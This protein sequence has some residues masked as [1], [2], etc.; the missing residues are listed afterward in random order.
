MKL[1]LQIILI[2]IV[3]FKTETLLSENNLFNVNNIKLD[4]N[5]KISNDT[6]ADKAIKKGF[7]ELI[8]K[9]LLKEDINKLSNLNFSSIKELV[10][11][12]QVSQIPDEKDNGELAS[13]SVTFDKDKIHELFYNQG[14]LYSEI[15]DKEIF[16][17]PVLIKE[18]EIYIFNNN[19]FYKYWNE[20]YTV[21]LIEFILPIENIE[22]IQKINKNKKNLIDIE[23][24]NLFKEYSKKNL[25]LVLIEEN[26]SKNNR[27]Y[28]KTKIQGKKISKSLNIK[29]ENEDVKSQYEQ[30]IKISKNELTNLVKSENLIDIRTPSFLNV[31]LDLNKTTN[32]VEFNLRV[33]NI[34]LVENVYVQEFNKDYLK[35]RIKYLGKLER[36]ID[37]FKKAKINL[38]FIN[39]QWFLKFI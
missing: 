14:I 22:I 28:L 29:K 17:L 3:F 1:Y 9:I 31:R 36:I 38:K 7:Q 4:K 18:T 35:L 25:A 24:D 19:F 15:L 12:Y 32:L 26:K 11:Y 23:I 37:Q 5:D 33:K 2:L 39:D 10:T 8:S 6:L 27:V 16:I 13:F 34:D 30:I 21:D 20:I